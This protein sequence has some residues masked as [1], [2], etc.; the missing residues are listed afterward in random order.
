MGDLTVELPIE[1]MDCAECTLHVQKAI[2]NVPHVKSAQVFLGSEKA[3]VYF[4]QNQENLSSIE[5]AV[6][7]AG[8]KVVQKKT[9]EVSEP[10]TVDFTK[11]IF[12][13]LG[14]VFGAV[15]FVAVVGEWLGLFEAI[16][17]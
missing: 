5:Q 17:K 7:E 14:F 8:Y 12:R 3:I 10:K 16:T 4:D 2:E 13:L 6:R 1:G 9:G 11:D 15:L